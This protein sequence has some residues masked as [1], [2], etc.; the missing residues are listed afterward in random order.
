MFKI[1]SISERRNLAASKS[2]LK[3]DMCSNLSV[4]VELKRII[5][6]LIS[7]I[8]ESGVDSMPD[9]YKAV[10]NAAAVSDDISSIFKNEYYLKLL[11]MNMIYKY[12]NGGDL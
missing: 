4:F 3:M 10:Y 9:L 12:S 5:Y 2:Q 7:V 11:I 8:N 1:V 6:H